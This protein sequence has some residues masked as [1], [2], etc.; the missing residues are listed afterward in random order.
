MSFQNTLTPDQDLTVEEAFGS[1][2][3]LKDYYCTLYGNKLDSFVERLESL[4]E[5]TTRFRLRRIRTPRS[6]QFIKISFNNSNSERPYLI[7]KIE[8]KGEGC[9]YERV[10]LGSIKRPTVNGGEKLAYPF[11]DQTILG[12]IANINDID[13]DLQ[14][15]ETPPWIDFC[16]QYTFPPLDIEYGKG[17]DLTAE[18]GQPET[19]LGCVI[20][21]MGGEG[22]IRDFF[23]EQ[24]MGFFDSI[25]YKW[26]QN[27]CKA[28]AGTYI[29]REEELKNN[30]NA[31]LS[32]LEQREALKGDTTEIDNQIQA[33]QKDTAE[34]NKII[35]GYVNDIAFLEKEK[36]NPF[37]TTIEELEARIKEAQE[38]IEAGEYLIEENKKQIAALDEQRRDILNP[39]GAERQEANQ[40]LRENRRAD[41]Q[42]RRQEP[43]R[44]KT[45]KSL[46]KDLD[47]ISRKDARQFSRLASRGSRQERQENRVTNRRQLG[48]QLGNDPFI[49]ASRE[50]VANQF[51]FEDSLVQLFMTEEEFEQYGLRGFDFMGG[52]RDAA[53]GIRGEEKQKRLKNFLSRIGICGLSKLGQRAVQ[54]LLGG[55]DLDTG[56]RAIVRAALSNMAP[57]IMEKLLVGLDPRV[58]QDIRDQVQSEFRDMPA[59]WEV[60]YRPGSKQGF[61]GET[62]ETAF[63]DKIDSLESQ[64]TNLKG[65]QGVIDYLFS[66]GDSDTIR[67]K[68]DIETRIAD[69]EAD[70]AIDYTQLI[71]KLQSLKVYTDGADKQGNIKAVLDDFK[72]DLD[73]EIAILDG[74]IIQAQ[75]DADNVD[76]R[77]WRNLSEEEQDELIERERQIA[78]DFANG[79]NANVRINQGSVGKALGNI[80][81]TIF[82]AYVDAIM[83]NVEIQELFS[84]LD[85][86]P[87]A[88]LIARLIA[89][90]DCPNVHF[91]Y[92]PIKS[93]LGSLTFDQCLDRGS[94]TIP[95]IPRIPK[96]RTIR[97]ELMDLAKRIIK[98]AWEDLVESTYAA[99][100]LKFLMIIENA[101][102]KALEAVGQFAAEAVQGP[103]ANF[104]SVINELICGGETG[105]DEIDQVSSSLL[106]SIGV[107][108]QK[109]QDLAEDTNPADLQGQYRQVMNSI[110][111][112][113][114]G[115]QLKELMVA[116]P[117]EADTLVLAR[118]SRTVSLQN[119]AFAIFFDSP[120]KVEA[121]FAAMGNF[122]TPE[123]RQLVRDNLANPQFEVNTG[124]SIC[125]TQEQLEN[126]QNQK[127][128]IWAD[129]GLSPDQIEENL[130]KDE[131]RDRE[132]CFEAADLLAKG[133]VSALKEAI[134][135]ALL[136]EE[137]GNPNGIV[138][139]ED[140]I[141]AKENDIL[142]EGV[143]RSLQRSYQNDMIGKRDAFL[144]NVLADT[145]DLP[146]KRHERRANSESFYIDYANSVEDWEAKEKR[147]NETAAGS[148]YFGVLSQEEPKGV[149]PDTVAIKM[150]E[151]LE[152]Q[153][154][155]VNF[156]FSP[157]QL[158]SRE[159]RSVRTGLL[160]GETQLRVPKVYL[161]QPDMVLNFSNG[162]EFQVDFNVDLSFTKYKQGE[163]EI[164]KDFGYKV[165]IFTTTETGVDT[166]N[167]FEDDLTIINKTREYGIF[168]PQQADQ[169]ASVVL[170]PY[171]VS[172]EDLNKEK[173]SYQSYLM[174]NLVN[175][176][177]QSASHAHIPV[178]TFDDLFYGKMIQKSFDTVSK[179]LLTTLDG[180]TSDGFNFGYE[181]DPLTPADLLYVNPES[182]PNDDSTWEYTYEEEDAVLGRS[183]TENSRVHFLDPNVYGGSF[184]SPPIYVEPTTFTGWLGLSQII[185]PEIDGC[186]PKRTDF[187]D[188]KQ[189]AEN[190]RKIETSIPQDPRLSED[191]ECVKRVPFDKI[192]DASTLAFIDGTVTATIR[193][194]VS[195][196]MLKSMPMFSFLEY[197]DSNYDDGFAQLIV[198]EMERGLTQQ[199]AFFGGRI[200]GYSYYLLFL[201]QAVQSAVRKI[202]N[203]QIESTPEIE[204]AR[205]TINDAQVDYRYPQKSDLEAFK[206]LS[207]LSQSEAIAAGAGSA[208]T[209]GFFALAFPAII[210]AG[211]A[212]A[213]P[214]AVSTA[215]V[216]LNDL[217]FASK[218]GLIESVKRSCK[219]L[220]KALVD[221]ELKFLSSKLEDDNR[222]RPYVADMSKYYLSLPDFMYGSTLKAGLMDI[223]KPQVGGELDTDYGDVREVISD[224]TLASLLT[225]LGLNEE[226]LATVAESGGLFIEKYIRTI[227][228]PREGPN[229]Q[230]EN[231]EDQQDPQYLNI[232]RQR[233]ST[234]KGVCNITEFRQWCLSIKDQIPAGLNISD[235]F[236]DARVPTG[237][238]G[239]Y[240]GS[241]GIKYGLRVSMI[242]ND[243]INAQLALGTWDL[244]FVAKEK[245][246][247][248]ADTSAIPL[249]SYERDIKDVK[250]VDLDFEDPNLGEDLKCYVDKM[251]SEPEYQAVMDYLLGLRRIPTI[252]AIYMNHTFI[253]SVGASESER[254]E[255]AKLLGFNTTSDD[256]KSE[257]LEDTKKECRRLFASFYRSD[258]FEP[259]DDN[260]ASLRE[261]VSRFLPGLFGVN[262]GLIHWLRRRKLRLR[263]FDKDG[264]QCKNAFQRIFSSE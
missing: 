101:L 163:V 242:P 194:Y 56:L 193:T 50:I 226:Q 84:I 223:E 216:S 134:D 128:K 244:E 222:F 17:N 109:L 52:L 30:P 187:L 39:L 115:K 189:I 123:Q 190:V 201:E 218:I 263:P 7:K 119:P 122:M 4:I 113:V 182:D 89:S 29:S 34:M 168:S 262:R 121:V 55:V 125:L 237:T 72:K 235:L 251:V 171:D 220:L 24:V 41:R 174:S 108:P 18:F 155:D 258:D 156:N 230:S 15:K 241:I 87:G 239:D 259:E 195:E 255:D 33:L 150:K 260:D 142:V 70:A 12:Y 229:L 1:G 210:A 102:C 2:Q 144:E 43:S 35:D 252:M 75:A 199:E 148:F 196:A 77:N 111:N 117:G 228:K 127:R 64:V 124:S 58:Q 143:F 238:T 158:P 81:E 31:E 133:P 247:S 138:Q 164:Q 79:A 249:V 213:T 92:P 208:I 105:D 53:K 38:Q 160:G 130:K 62:R 132:A 170:A 116:N 153:T 151:E 96:I 180:E 120:D 188:I 49:S 167:D 215:L 27:N 152:V 98:E 261:V 85:K 135:K 28:L 36:E 232:V 221:N 177:L 74:Q 88:R 19:I 145:T 6:A 149:F 103:N 13:Q 65:V 212:I 185:V 69:L 176:Q 71:Q 46:R 100:T 166:D 236:G 76:F 9:D 253:S 47:D 203:G 184:R 104:G 59:P 60:G 118:L 175:S 95:R 73:L 51:P 154:F 61:S 219:V 57:S 11:N 191:P 206:E 99:V 179:G 91:I 178:S 231:R 146:L 8:V 42:E 114:S 172:I 68:E 67:F 20:D 54:C 245:T 204:E 21:N 63:S 225:S 44:R 141:T 22:A 126:Y 23:L 207:E 48:E 78:Q 25:A 257:I 227:D 90:F 169:S 200:Q 32:S 264:N 250:F 198:Q 107:T 106:S 211:A 140:P 147:F 217:R 243:S 248:F 5:S 83:D 254:D 14:A 173:V 214:V 136:P 86:F 139:L 157:K 131:E 112:V 161:K 165:D 3:G 37:G 197:K 137:C 246:F 183:A 240:E 181:S 66:G 192:S 16:I 159:T 94:I 129:C 205:K 256:W 162:K 97:K 26:N 10:P 93:F 186:K 40:R 110:S 82:D 224:N 234:L 202:D 209:L 233:P 45:K 80:Q